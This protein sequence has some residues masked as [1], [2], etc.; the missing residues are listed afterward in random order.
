MRRFLVAFFL[1]VSTAQAQDVSPSVELSVQQ[2][3]VIQLS[4]QPISTSLADNLN[5]LADFEAHMLH[6]I[7]RHKTAPENYLHGRIRIIR[8]VAKTDIAKAEEM[9]KDLIEQFQRWGVTL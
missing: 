6:R 1:L 7:T 4:V 2:L 3:S 5:R 9:A 8:N